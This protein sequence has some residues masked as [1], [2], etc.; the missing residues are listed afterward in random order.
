MVSS[1]CT[2]FAFVALTTNIS[3][4]RYSRLDFCQSLLQPPPLPIFAQISILGACALWSERGQSHALWVCS[5]TTM[6]ASAFLLATFTLLASFPLRPQLCLR[7]IEACPPLWVSLV[8]MPTVAN[9]LLLHQCAS[10]SGLAYPSLTFVPALLTLQWYASTAVYPTQY[11]C[12]G[13]V[14]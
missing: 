6:E 4:H 1:T 2:F 7:S 12:V 10:V 3:I 11:I 5:R 9:T 14:A 8:L 13:I